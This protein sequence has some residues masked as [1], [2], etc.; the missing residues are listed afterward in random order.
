MKQK[1]KT[2]QGCKFFLD[3]PFAV[4]DYTPYF[5]IADRGKVETLLNSGD[6]GRCMKHSQM[7]PDTEF[8][9]DLPAKNLIIVS[10]AVSVCVVVK[11]LWKCDDWEKKKSEDKIKWGK[12]ED[13]KKSPIVIAT[14]S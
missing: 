3:S 5:S 12:Y 10:S 8:Q 14:S 9:E 1:P 11:W 4:K 6:Y 2:C 7:F 13:N